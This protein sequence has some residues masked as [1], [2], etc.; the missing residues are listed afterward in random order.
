MVFMFLT[1]IPYAHLA[2]VQAKEQGF[3]MFFCLMD[4][5][6]VHKFQISFVYLGY[7]SRSS[8]L[9]PIVFIF[10]HLQEQK[11]R[12]VMPVCIRTIPNIVCNVC[13]GWLEDS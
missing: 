5:W 8:T 10:L 13:E 2:N 6:Y 4:L 11:K 7:I 3:D 12:G 9:H 1:Q